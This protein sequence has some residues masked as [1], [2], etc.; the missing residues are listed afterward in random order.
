MLKWICDRIDGKATGVE[1]PIGIMPAPHE[2]DL[3]GSTVTAADLTELLAVDIAGWQ[4][5]IASVEESYAKCG[6]RI[7]HALKQ[8]LAALKARLAAA[9]KTQKPAKKSGCQS[10]CCC[11]K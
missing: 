3:T 11:S 7:P 4:Q 5:E 9:A 10:G 1:T 6:N 8:E 2:L